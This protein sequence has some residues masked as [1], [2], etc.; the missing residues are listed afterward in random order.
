P[1]ARRVEEPGGLELCFHLHESLIQRTEPGEPHRFD[2]E[3]QFAAR[4]VDR[5]D[6]AHFDC[7][8]LAQRER[9]PLRLMAEEHAA[10]LR[11]RVLQREIQMS[12][13]GAT[14][15]RYLA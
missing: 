6:R 5:R 8:P 13:R 14:A 10:N 1:L 9:E 3:L 2:V 15:P 7:E 12:R 4:V 11:G